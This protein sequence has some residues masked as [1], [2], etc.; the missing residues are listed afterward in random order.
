M[1]E[2]WR[3]ALEISADLVRSGESPADRRFEVCDETG[4]LVFDLAFSHLLASPK[5]RR[6]ANT[7]ALQTD[8]E[9]AMATS[10]RLKGEVAA[11]MQDVRATLETTRA[12]LKRSR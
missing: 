1:V 4:R 6:F 3:A 12:L 5:P 2:A 9:A 8:L 7:D 11:V 10:R